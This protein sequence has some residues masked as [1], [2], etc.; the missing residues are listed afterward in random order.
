MTDINQIE[1]SENR[2]WMMIRSKD[3]FRVG[4][5]T[6]N[7]NDSDKSYKNGGWLDTSSVVVK[8]DPR[9][10]WENILEE[11]S[12]LVS[13]NFWKETKFDL[14]KYSTFNLYS[15]NYYHPFRNNLQKYC[16][17]DNKS[18]LRCESF[19]SHCS[20]RR[21]PPCSLKNYFAS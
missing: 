11:Q 5:T 3:R 2:E 9:Q 18:I 17:Q 10:E 7:F 12:F 14:S 1:F 4:R 6:E 16:N 20:V 13:Y 15:P 8:I 21:S 19:G